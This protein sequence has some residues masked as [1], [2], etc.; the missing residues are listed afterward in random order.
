MN[1]SFF[2]MLRM[3]ELYHKFI[4]SSI[5]KAEYSALTDF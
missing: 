5:Q 3:I 2:A 1:I 4:Y